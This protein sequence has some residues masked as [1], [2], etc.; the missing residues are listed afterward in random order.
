MEFTTSVAMV[1]PTFYVPLAQAAEEAGF[2]AVVLPD[3]IGYPEESDTAYPY[4]TDGDRAFL[5]NKPFIEPLIASAAMA[6]ATS[7][8]RFLTGVLKLPVRH[9]VIF[10]KEVTSLAVISGNRFDLG[11]GTSPW[12]DDYEL[13]GLP[14][15][16]RGRRF[17]ECIEIIRGLETGEYFEYH[18]EF[19]DFPSFKINPAPTEPIKVIIGGHADVNIERAARIADGWMPAGMSTEQITAIVARIHERRRELGRD[20]L[21]FDVYA[22]NADSMTLDGIERLAAAGV[23][24]T[25]GGFSKFMPYSLEADSE[26]LQD[27]IDAIRRFGDEVISKLR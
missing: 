24:H 20:H 10:A 25:G 3:S 5:E 14:W 21:P 17:E 19:Y 15:E 13:V 18:G 27:K 16:R 26:P 12:P 6:T 9:P 22:S 11:V 23:T 2:S 7:R 4:T 8:I 1:D